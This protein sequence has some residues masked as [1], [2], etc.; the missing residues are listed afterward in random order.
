MQLKRAEKEGVDETA[1][2]EAEDVDATIELVV[3]RVKEKTEEQSRLAEARGRVGRGDLVQDAPW[4]AQRMVVPAD[5]SYVHRHDAHKR[6]ESE[7][8]DSEITMNGLHIT[9]FTDFDASGADVHDTLR[10]KAGGASSDE[11]SSADDEHQAAIAK[12]FVDAAARQMDRCYALHVEGFVS[13]G[14]DFDQLRL[15]LLQEAAG[16][17]DLLDSKLCEDITAKLR[18]SWV[19]TTFPPGTSSSTPHVEIAEKYYRLHVRKEN[20]GEVV[21]ERTWGLSAT[22]EWF[23]D[24]EGQA[25][26]EDE[27]RRYDQGSFN[28][29]YTAVH[30]DSETGHVE[31]MHDQR[32][33]PV[34]RNKCG[35]YLY[36]TANEDPVAQR[37]VFSRTWDPAPRDG[38][39]P[40]GVA[41]TRTG[42]GAVPTGKQGWKGKPPPRPLGEPV[43]EPSTHVITGTIELHIA[44]LFMK[45]GFAQDPK[46]RTNCVLPNGERAPKLEI[47]RAIE[48]I[49]YAGQALLDSTHKITDKEH[50]EY[51]SRCVLTYNEAHARPGTGAPEHKNQ[52]NFQTG[53]VQLAD[54]L[55]RKHPFFEVEILSDGNPEIAIGLSYLLGEHATELEQ[56]PGWYPGSVGF[57]FDNCDLCDGT[58]GVIVPSIRGVDKD[59]KPQPLQKGDKVQCGLEWSAADGGF[60]SDLD[61]HEVWFAV[62]RKGDKMPTELSRRATLRGFPEGWIGH[63]DAESPLRRRLYPTI[64]M[65]RCSG[66]GLA[67][68]VFLGAHQPGQAIGKAYLPPI[69]TEQTAIRT[70]HQHCSGMTF[71]TVRQGG[72]TYVVL[73]GLPD[74]ATGI[75]LRMDGLQEGMV[76]V[77]AGR[78][79]LTGKEGL[80]EG[81]WL[82]YSAQKIL[83]EV[84]TLCAPN[85][86]DEV[87]EDDVTLVFQGRFEALS[88]PN[89]DYNAAHS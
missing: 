68:A 74:G 56:Q 15:T 34:Y 8:G 49:E 14:D 31:F 73:C 58:G 21:D 76:L 69:E 12:S 55:G 35:R 29:I 64:G 2:A 78:K 67:V 3:A 19:A 80:L 13:L 43:R 41:S 18:K 83:E 63:E 32:G 51:G 44:E 36:R 16:G 10:R 25:H 70:K 66:H 77:Q 50:P 1:L 61:A 28:G 52:I 82:N 84:E 81:S 57:H 85:P 20:D 11:E 38:K 23:Q 53:V 22:R 59:G 45:P 26:S 86:H 71:R 6:L 87:P 65:S 24:V 48:T 46:R 54:P 42:N 89:K 79:R 40:R 72:R 7:E 27:V 47:H 5:H 30:V 9:K 39:P 88:E 60:R 75:Q 4:D 62:Q 37:W 17:E 33:F